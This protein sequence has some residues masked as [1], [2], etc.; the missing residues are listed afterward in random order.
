MTIKWKM[1]D[2]QASGEMES[3]SELDIFIEGI[4]DSYKGR[5]VWLVPSLF[6]MT[7]CLSL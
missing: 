4:G 5:D 3:E 2:S 7:R 6:S 1:C